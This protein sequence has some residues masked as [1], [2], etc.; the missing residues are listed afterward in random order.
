M[1][2]VTRTPKQGQES[3]HGYEESSGAN[4]AAQAQIQRLSLPVSEVLIDN[5][6]N[7]NNHIRGLWNKLFKMLRQKKS[8]ESNLE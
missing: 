2:E 1:G 7:K 6:K 5:E 8:R 3:D 4:T